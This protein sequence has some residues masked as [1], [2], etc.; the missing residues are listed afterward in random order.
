MWTFINQTKNTHTTSRRAFFAMNTSTDFVRE[1]I[2]PTR[3]LWQPKIVHNKFNGV[4]FLHQNQN[5]SS[6]TFHR[7]FFSL[8]IRLELKWV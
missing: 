4:D 3:S 2:V 6:G 8:D 5:K 1:E 7:R